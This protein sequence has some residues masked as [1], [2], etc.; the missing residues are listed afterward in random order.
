MKRPNRGKAPPALKDLAVVRMSPGSKPKFEEFS[1]NSNTQ[2]ALLAVW[3]A[4]KYGVPVDRTLALVDARFR[5]SQNGDGSW[6]YVPKRDQ[7]PDSMTCA[8]LLGLAVGRG[9]ARGD[10][11][12]KASAADPDIAR[13]LRYLG[14]RIG[15]PGERA[16]KGPRLGTGH[17]IGANAH[18]DLYFLWSVERVAVIYDLRTIAGKDWYAWGAPILVDHQTDDGGWHDVFPE[19]V[20]TCFALLFLKRVNVAQDLTATL[21]SFDNLVDQADGGK[22][23]RVPSK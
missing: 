12:G 9:I 20:D 22:V 8:G 6:G 15:K 21:R 4:R 3:T 17:V 14:E 2:F 11:G 7:W 10:E 1:D 16:R 5:A 23:G 13:G 18:G 19:T